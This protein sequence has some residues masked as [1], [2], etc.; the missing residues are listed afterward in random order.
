MIYCHNYSV[1]IIAFVENG[2][3]VELLRIFEDK[4]TEKEA[5]DKKKAL[6]EE[7]KNEIAKAIEN[8]TICQIRNLFFYPTKYFAIKVN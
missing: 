7:V 3:S 8:E 4:L 6:V 2:D 5:K 1:F